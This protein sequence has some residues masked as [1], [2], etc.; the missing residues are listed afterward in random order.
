MVIIFRTDAIRLDREVMD[1]LP[2]RDVQ[3][4]ESVQ[5]WWTAV[6]T[7]L[8]PP[9]RFCGVRKN[10]INCP[11]TSITIIFCRSAYPLS[12][13]CVTGESIESANGV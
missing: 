9:P 13:P 12:V 1:E 10:P 2:G 11:S 7:T 3:L 6:Q 5:G 8:Q 4:E